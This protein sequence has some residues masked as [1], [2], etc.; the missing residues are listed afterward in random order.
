MILE[1]RV[2]NFA[3]ISETNIEF[4]EGFNVLTGETGAG[5]S[6]IIDALLTIAGRGSADFLRKGSE[7]A[8]VEALFTTNEVLRST[9]H[10]LEGEDFISLKKVIHSNGK[11]KQYINGTFTSQSRIK[12]LFGRLLHV[13]GQ[14]E[15]KDLYDE[16]YQ[17]ELFDL[18]CENQNL[19]T[20]LKELL[21]EARQRKKALLEIEEKEKT[22][23]KEL[24]YIEYQISEIRNAALHD[25][26]EEERLL[27]LRQR[28]LARERILKNLYSVYELI[29]G[30]DVNAFDLLSEANKLFSEL[31]SEESFF[32]E[33]Q[34]ELKGV[35][36]T[37]KYRAMEIKSFIEKLETT[38]ED[39]DA[40]EAR[41]DII[42]KLK[43]KYGGS[44]KEIK[45][46]LQE[47]EVRWEA[48]KNIEHKKEGIEREL[49][50]SR[51]KIMEAANK[52]TEIRKERCKAFE[53]KVK[54]ELIQLGMPKAEFK[55]MFNV[56]SFEKAEDM[57]FFGKEG[58]QFLF[59]S[60]TGEELKPLSKIASGGELS[61]V[62]LAVKNI[63]P[64]EA[65]MTVIFDEV[66]VGVGGKTAEMIGR[67]LKEISQHHQVI[68]I[69]HLPQV[70]IFG[71]VHLKVEKGEKDGRI[72]IIVKDL[73]EE[74]RVME[75][76]RM[77]GGDRT[78]KGVE[79]AKEL[80]EKA[81]FRGKG[82]VV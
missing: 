73:K 13:Y 82:G 26:D 48:L 2:K 51:E 12:E 43:K 59:S 8:V 31:G 10:E 28:L 27:G 72:D 29:Y 56:Q 37:L 39:I 81:T 49:A 17:R 50:M 58:V 30:G 16:A 6:L 47:L 34:E 38:E 78:S 7:Q 69:T 54:K 5:K 20:A 11:T 21:V 33:S 60:H 68:C 64:R 80:L 24:D 14:N 3:V 74:E 36:E 22:R 9:F 79:Y 23:G 53:E 44:I 76:T 41:L 32:C 66:D 40:I 45:A 77:L 46:F 52:L 75:I 67:K 25:D 18:Y 63:I 70:A 4:R 35:A 65:S 61:R 71:D 57:P 1:L 42:F 15:T 62:M 55:V 19:L